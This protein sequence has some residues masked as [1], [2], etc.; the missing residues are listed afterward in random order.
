M[1]V[2][3]GLDSIYLQASAIQQESAC[4]CVCT[5]LRLGERECCMHSCLIA[6]ESCNLPHSQTSV[7]VWE[8]STA[9]EVCL[10]QPGSERT[11]WSCSLASVKAQSQS[12]TVPARQ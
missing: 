8:N 3:K 7:R 12:P 5:A 11:H 4:L 2:E 6:E 9:M 1:A 10:L